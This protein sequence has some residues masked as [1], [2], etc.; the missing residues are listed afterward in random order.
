M[1]IKH[2]CF[3]F[4]STPALAVLPLDLN[5]SGPMHQTGSVDWA[6]SLQPSSRKQHGTFLECMHRSTTKLR[7]DNCV[8]SQYHGYSTD[9]HGTSR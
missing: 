9:N 3:V 4:L 8:K 1:C 5:L 7:S 2:D 6:I